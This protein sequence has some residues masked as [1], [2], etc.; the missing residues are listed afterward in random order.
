MEIN[1]EKLQA[2]YEKENEI[3][4]KTHKKSGEL[5]REAHNSMV[6][7]VPMSWMERW[8]GR[9]PIFVKEAK[10]SHF[11][12]VDGNHYI[13]F[14]LGDTGS[15]TGHA[16]EP[17][18]K[19]ITE[20][21]KKGTTFLLP[22]ED[23]IWVG[24]ELQRRFGVKYWQFTTSATDAN[25][26]ALRI[27]RHVTKRPY[28]LI[29]NGSYHG[30]V[31]ETV[32][33]IAPDGSVVSK[34]GSLGPPV[35]P[36]LTTRVI[37]F[38]DIEALEN[39]LKDEQVALVMAE[40]V[41]TNCGIVHPLPGYHDKL[42]ELTKKYGTLLLFDE[43][44]SL[45]A[46]TGGCIKALG[47]SPDIV[48]IGKTLAAGIP[49]GA[50]GLTEELGKASVAGI[51]KEDSDL[52]GI[53]GTLAA[54]ALTMAVM[55][56]TLGEVLTEEFYERNSALAAKF[57]EG[58]QQVINEFDLPWNTTQLGCRTEYWFTKEPAI[59]GGSGEGARDYL[60]DMYIHIAYANRGILMTPFHN[61]A[62]FASSTT[63]ADVDRHTEVLR[64][65]VQLI[66]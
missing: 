36:K 11:Q 1:R 13:D 8:A 63:E 49:A 64:E 40:P 48:V 39:A 59:N 27:A 46:G 38:N 57:N 2:Q 6:K 3:F 53:G 23:C 37:E 28:V 14:C 26:F 43:T 65:I 33:T 21:A 41:M 20:Q 66:V 58:V 44:H 9:Y 35:E 5:F 55:K 54:N 34:P 32:A 7:G 47:L 45:S 24:D 12:D 29:F 51:A 30:S 10:G 31:D 15:M 18:V 19:A 60:L 42:R 56:A 61:M 62:L 50:F 17:V 22:T 4:E 25:R 16:T 52:G